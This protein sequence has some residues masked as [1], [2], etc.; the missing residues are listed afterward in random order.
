MTDNLLIFAGTIGNRDWYPEYFMIDLHNIKDR[1]DP[2][3]TGIGDK[4]LSK[5]VFADQLNQL[6][7]PEIVEFVKYIIQQQ[8]GFKTLDLASVFKLGQFDGDNKGFLLTL[9]TKFFNRESIEYEIQVIFVN[10]N[11]SVLRRTVCLKGI[12]ETFPVGQI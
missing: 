1:P 9:A 4:D 3:L 5:A 8:N 11:S 6:R 12:P 7:Y 2:L 10:P